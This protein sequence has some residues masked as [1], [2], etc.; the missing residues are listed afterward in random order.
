MV[1]GFYESRPGRY[2]IYFSWKGEK[3][4]LNKYVNGDPLETPAQC[5]RL[6]A[7]IRSQIDAKNFDPSEWAKDKPFLFKKAVESWIKLKP[8]TSETLGFGKRIAEKILIPHFGEKDIREIRSIHV[9]EFLSNLKERGCGDKYL[10]QHHGR[11]SS[12]PKVSP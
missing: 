5:E 12:L 8:V 10:L 6:L 2:R 4:L 3:F 11:T 9:A 7:K 1:G